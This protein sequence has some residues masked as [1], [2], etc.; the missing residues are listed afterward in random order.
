M[1][2]EIKVK[3]EFTEGYRERYTEACL[4]ELRKRD[5]RKELE[6][7]PAREAETA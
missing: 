3:V 4:E 6:N 7:E 1:K 5:Q 2:K